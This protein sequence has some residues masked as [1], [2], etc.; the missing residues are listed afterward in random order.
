MQHSPIPVSGPARRRHPRHVPSG[1]Q[2]G[3]TLIELMV[4]VVVT[5]IIAA[6]ALPS[7]SSY[8][9]RSRIAEAAGNLP[10][11]RT[12]VEQ[13]FQDNRTYS[14]YTL[15]T[16]AGATYFTYSLS[17]NATTYT[18]TATGVSAQGMGG[19]GYAINQ[20]NARATT[21]LPTGWSGSGSTCWVIKKGGA[22]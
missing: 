5:A 10:D 11:L 15:P 6:V 1:F 19:F 9:T 7:Y 3:F 12:K 18:I 2:R 4:V 13:Y 17:A 20:N 21:A 14:G 22:C 8:V 16:P